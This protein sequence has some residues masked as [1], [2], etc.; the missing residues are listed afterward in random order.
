MMTHEE[1]ASS[2]EILGA[3]N[4]PLAYVERAG[5]E[6][7]VEVK[8]WLTLAA[9]REIMHELKTCYGEALHRVE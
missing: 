3:K 2:K 8:G 5:G 9:A 4:Q 6:M 1:I 7:Y